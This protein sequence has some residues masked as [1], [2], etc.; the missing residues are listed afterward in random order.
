MAETIQFKHFIGEGPEAVAL[1][2]A[3]KEGLAKH[4]AA[5]KDFC[6]ERGFEG[7]W[8]YKD[9]GT[10]GPLFSEELT[11]EEAKARGLKYHGR[12]K[13]MYAYEPRLNTSVGK[14]LAGA[15]GV[16]NTVFFS[17]NKFLLKETGMA[18]TVFAGG[19]VGHSSAG[20]TADVVLV[21]YPLIQGKG[22]SVG[23]EPVPP[24]W[25]R[26]CKESEFL[27]AQGL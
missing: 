21:N 16:L 20:H 14:A 10:E 24:A 9:R 2:A 8:S 23:N 7:T 18:H 5:L 22:H 6:A 1:I 17:T 4:E 15:I 3:A 27:A 26:P 13:D 11:A 19:R 12:V 25:L